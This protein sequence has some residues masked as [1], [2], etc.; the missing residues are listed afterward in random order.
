[1]EPYDS[2]WRPWP[3]AWSAIR[4]PPSRTGHPAWGDRLAGHAF[5]ADAPRC[6]R[7]ARQ[8]WRVAGIA[9]RLPRHAGRR[10]FGDRCGGGPA[11]YGVVGPDPPAGWPDGQRARWGGGPRRAAEAPLRPTAR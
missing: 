7:H 5:H 4:L 1:M 8:L 11:G 6:H 2:G 9:R 10:A 3:V